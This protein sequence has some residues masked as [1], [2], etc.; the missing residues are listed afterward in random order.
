ME[1]KWI[2]K[3][4]FERMKERAIGGQNNNTRDRID[5][6][7]IVPGRGNTRHLLEYSLSLYLGSRPNYIVYRNVSDESIEEL[8]GIPFEEFES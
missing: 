3:N 7:W 5:S 6:Y 4:V 8:S 2:S 1:I